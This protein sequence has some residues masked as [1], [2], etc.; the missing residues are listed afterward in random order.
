MDRAVSFF[1]ISSY[2]RVQSCA[3]T[4]FSCNRRGDPGL[5]WSRGRV[6]SETLGTRLLLPTFFNWNKSKLFRIKNRLNVAKMK[7][8]EILSVTQLTF[9]FFFTLT[10][11]FNVNLAAL[12]KALRSFD[13]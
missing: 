12:L 7:R 11:Q 1:K 4:S 13:H 3:S 5:V 2:I 8:R 10:L 6:R 9:F